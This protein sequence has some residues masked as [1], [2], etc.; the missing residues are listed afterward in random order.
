VTCY[1]AAQIARKIPP[2][3]YFGTTKLNCNFI[4]HHNGLFDSQAEIILLWLRDVPQ[5]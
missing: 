5:I 2:I 3:R 4:R 1:K